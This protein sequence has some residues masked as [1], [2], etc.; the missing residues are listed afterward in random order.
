MHQKFRQE[1][2]YILL[3][4]G[5]LSHLWEISCYADQGII[6]AASANCFS[7][8]QG[9]AVFPDLPVG[10]EV[11]SPSQS[12]EEI[13]NVNPGSLGPPV[14]RLHEALRLACYFCIAGHP[15]GTMLWTREN[16]Q[17]DGTLDQRCASRCSGLKVIV[18]K[19]KIQAI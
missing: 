16:I 11:R 8:H 19:P 17:R 1:K 14:A 12:L 3:N 15:P 6:F 10:S 2:P 9:I 4:W 7:L 18:H 5:Y 13:A